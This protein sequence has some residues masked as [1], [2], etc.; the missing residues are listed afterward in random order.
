VDTNARTSVRPELMVLA[1]GLG[2]KSGAWTDASAFCRIATDKG[3]VPFNTC[4]AFAID[5][6]AWRAASGMLLPSLG[7]L[8]GMNEV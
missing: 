8:F 6:P 7:R 1:D 4:D 5:T 2:K 3:P